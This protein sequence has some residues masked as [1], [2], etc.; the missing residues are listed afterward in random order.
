[1]NKKHSGFS[2]VELMIA[3]ALGLFLISGLVYLY[4]GSKQ[5]YSTQAAVARVQ[6]SLRFAFEFFAYD[7]RMAGFTGCVNQRDSTPW[8]V[9]DPPGPQLG[10][11]GSVRGFENGSGW[12][13]PNANWPVRVAGTDVLTVSSVSNDCGSNLVSPFSNGSQ[14]FIASNNCG[15]Q[16][17][18]VLVVSD[19]RRADIFRGSFSN[20]AGKV[21]VAHGSNNNTQPA[22]T[23][24]NP[25]SA[26]GSGKLVSE[27]CTNAGIYKGDAFLARLVGWTFYVALNDRGIPALYRGAFNAGLPEELVE[28][29]YDMQLEFGLDTIDDTAFVA[30][31]YRTANNVAN[32]GQVISVRVTFAARS[33]EDGVMPDPKPYLPSFN[34][35][36]ASDRRYRQ[37][38]TTVIGL[39][40]YVQ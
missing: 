9:A 33:N 26:P 12:V 16:D 31:Q 20:S 35:A 2:L 36:A 7:V 39:R 18:E 21:N 34:G 6:E 10:L 5:S 24:C 13:I 4:L 29:V 22:V 8:V 32:W 40:N 30:D 17:G 14:L 15:F 3:I 19:C 28:G 1:M 27:E 23:P 11:S 25:P 37:E 38:Y